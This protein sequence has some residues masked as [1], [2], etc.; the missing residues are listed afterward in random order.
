MSVACEEVVG[1][2]PVLAPSVI[3]EGDQDLAPSLSWAPPLQLSAHQAM[4]LL[5]GAAFPLVHRRPT[6]ELAGPAII[7]FM[8]TIR[9]CCCVMLCLSVA[10]TNNLQ[11][12]GHY[13][14][15]LNAMLVQYYHLQSL[16]S[17]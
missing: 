7:V 4:L 6:A 10:S 14:R 16:F 11:Q 15:C 8:V 17:L 3:V 2:L 9:P 5:L 12:A 13:D 1:D